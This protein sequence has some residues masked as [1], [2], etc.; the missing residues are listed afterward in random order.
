MN[1]DL[2]LPP[3][4]KGLLDYPASSKTIE[5]ATFDFLSREK[6]KFHRFL[7]EYCILGRGTINED[8][9]DVEEVD[10]DGTRGTVSISFLENAYSG[11]PDREQEETHWEDIPFHFSPSR[12]KVI[13]EF[14]EP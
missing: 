12:D 11:C 8:S 6:H 14:F 13:L 9:V 7:G 5:S 10:F 3:W 2:S 1:C 4:F